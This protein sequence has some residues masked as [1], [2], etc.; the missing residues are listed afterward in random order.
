MR[1]DYFVFL[2]SFFFTFCFFSYIRSEM[3]KVLVGPR[4]LIKDYF[5]MGKV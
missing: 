3:G 5:V 2:F 1:K 4:L